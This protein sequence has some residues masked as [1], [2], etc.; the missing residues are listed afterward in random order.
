MLTI[1][2]VVRII[3]DLRGKMSAFESVFISKLE[4]AEDFEKVFNQIS[5]YSGRKMREQLALAYKAVLFHLLSKLGLNFEENTGEI[6]SKRLK[7]CTTCAIL[8]PWN[9]RVFLGKE[10]SASLVISS[11]RLAGKTFSATQRT[12]SWRGLISVLRLMRYGINEEFLHSVLLNDD[13]D[14]TIHLIAQLVWDFES[15]RIPWTTEAARET[16]N[17]IKSWKTL[18][19]LRFL[20]EHEGATVEEIRQNMEER[21]G[22]KL[23]NKAVGSL[24]GVLSRLSRDHDSIVKKDGERYILNPVFKE[25]I[26][27]AKKRP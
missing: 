10:S 22:R 12:I 2:D 6:C 25:A 26:R 23:P 5:S 11:K 17:R 7:R 14:K 27:Q 21:L 4:D 8:Y 24:I 15:R 1:L 20:A 19:V 18:E 16:L 13:L 9:Q 3:G